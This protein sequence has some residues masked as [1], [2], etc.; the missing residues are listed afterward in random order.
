LVNPVFSSRL[1]SLACG[2]KIVKEIGAPDQKLNI[3]SGQCNF[4][5]K[6]LW[7]TKASTSLLSTVNIF[8][9]VQNI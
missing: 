2:H 7:H 6:I 3:K 4:P 1:K 9:G 5:P 8:G